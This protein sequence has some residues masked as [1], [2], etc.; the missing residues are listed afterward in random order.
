MMADDQVSKHKN[1]VDFMRAT[2]KTV[3]HDNWPNPAHLGGSAAFVFVHVYACAPFHSQTQTEIAIRNSRWRNSK[4]V[5]FDC[6]HVTKIK[7]FSNVCALVHSL[8]V[9]FGVFSLHLFWRSRIL[10]LWFGE[11]CPRNKFIAVGIA[12]WKRATAT[13]TTTITGTVAVAAAAFAATAAAV[14]Q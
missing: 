3:M 9:C 10:F 8:A 12:W 6:I 4:T 7:I 1:T 13:T 5:N 11:C 14:P 2:E